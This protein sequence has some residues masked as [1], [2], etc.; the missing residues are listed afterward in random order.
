MLLISPIDAKN[1]K[2]ILPIEWIDFRW[3]KFIDLKKFLIV[4]CLSSL[5]SL[6]WASWED[7]NNLS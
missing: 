4:E 7:Y 1:L 5:S 3:M 2:I 6:F